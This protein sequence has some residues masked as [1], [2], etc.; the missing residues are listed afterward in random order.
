MATEIKVPT[1]GESVTEATVSKWFKAVGEAVEADAPLLEL[2]TDKVTMEVNAPAAGVLAEILAEEGA[3]VEVGALL[4]TLSEGSDAAPE[5][6]GVSEPE[7][8]VEAVAPAAG[9]ATDVV[10]PQ[11]GESVAEGSISGW[12]KKVGDV[13]AADEPLCELE[14]DKVTMEVNAPVAGTLIE[15]LAEGTEVSVGAVIARIGDVGYAR[16]DLDAEDAESPRT[17][18]PVAARLAS[19]APTCPWPGRSQAVVEIGLDPNIARRRARMAA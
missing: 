8:A 19:P 1:L 6:K 11:L 4:G 5:S 3:E 14:T 13:V 16:R 2:E 10:V 9:P 18:T 15:I 7:G 12:M 17:S